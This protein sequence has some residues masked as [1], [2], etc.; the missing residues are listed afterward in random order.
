MLPVLS[1]KTRLYGSEKVKKTQ[2]FHKQRR[3]QLL[4]DSEWLRSER[5][6]QE[7]PSVWFKAKRKELRR[8]GSKQ[9]E[10]VKAEPLS[11]EFDCHSVSSVMIHI[12]L[13]VITEIM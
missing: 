3:F 7:A 2:T 13:S 11:D 5:H 6:Q 4:V 9:A 1:S 10:K 12:I 8:L